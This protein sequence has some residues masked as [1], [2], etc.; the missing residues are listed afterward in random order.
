MIKL[1]RSNPNTFIGVILLVVLAVFVLPDRLPQF[2]SEL[3]PYLF[4]GIPCGRLPAAKDLAAHQSIIGR[5]A[6]DPLLLEIAASEID[7]DDKL[8]I[9]LS[10][11]NRSLGTV[12]LVYQEDNISVAA[13]DDLTDGFGF[14]VDPAPADGAKERTDPNAETYAEAD[15]RLLGPR[16]KCE[17]STELRAAT[18]MIA[19][20]GTAQAWY[21]MSVAGTQ[22]TQG[23]G[24]REI[25]ADQGLDILSEGVVFSEE[26]VI[27][28]RA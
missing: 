4:G 18:A 9:R 27:E 1:D 19:D 13:A 2:I 15:I 7:A 28:A 22:Q 21:R 25:Y 17:H 8:V 20:G 12:P 14:I 24:T 26:L 10:V 11:T 5:S 16:Q 3:S 23:E 6:A